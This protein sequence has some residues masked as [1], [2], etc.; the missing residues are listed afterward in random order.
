MS[1]WEGRSGSESEGVKVD[2]DKHLPDV[3]LR[4]VRVGEWE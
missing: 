4:G 2:E 3:R 1:V